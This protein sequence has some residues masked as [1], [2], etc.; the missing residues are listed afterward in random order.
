MAAETRMYFGAQG[1]LLAS[2]RECEAEVFLRWFG[3]TREQLDAEY[4]PYEDSSVFLVIADSHDEVLGAVRLLVPGGAAGLKTLTDIGDE[5]WGVDGTRASA[6]VG[7]DLGTTWEIAT[8]GVRRG[9]AASGLRL[10]LALYHGLMTVAR[11]NRVTSFVA[12]LDERVR[13][14]LG[15]VGI[16]MR[17]LPGTSTAAYLGSASSTPVFAHFTPMVE[18]QRRQF[19]DSYRLVTLG[20]G[21]DGVAVPSLAGFRLGSRGSAAPVGQPVASPLA[22]L[23]ARSTLVGR[24]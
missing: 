23:A 9:T 22:V 7:L 19:P 21:L 1:A 10:S 24:S 4:G 2:A 13:R 8:L 6:A 16:V 5:P 17:A 3:N 15:S 14:L 18:N 11:A 12:I 20:I